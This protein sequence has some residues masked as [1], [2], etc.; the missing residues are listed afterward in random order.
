[1]LRSLIKLLKKIPLDFAQYEVR[2]TTKGKL[3]ACELVGDGRGRRALD[4][5]CRCG[6]W[7]EKLKARGYDVV[8]IDLEPHYAGALQVDADKALPFGD[9]EFDLIWCTEVIEHLKDP[10]F[11]VAE[12]KR[13]LRPEGQFVLTTPNN[14]F[15]FFQMFEK[16]GTGVAAITNEDHTVRFTY[17]ELRKLVGGGDEYGFF[18]YFIYKRTIKGAPRL[19]SP[20]IVLKYRKPAKAASA[21]RASNAEQCA[22]KS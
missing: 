2:C 14:D 22:G 6:Y 4:V 7:S 3:I 19:L 21:F 8:S 11:T 12:C 5:G 13:V 1:M 18:P 16:I 20:T 9:E 17:D 15:W 10:A